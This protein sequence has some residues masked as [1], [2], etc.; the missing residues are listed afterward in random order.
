MYRARVFL[1]LLGVCRNQTSG[2]YALG[3]ALANGY[4]FH[5]Q[6]KAAE[7]L[8]RVLSGESP[9]DAVNLSL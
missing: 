3:E 8:V 6:A 7:E 2:L 5:R 4:E 9:R 1:N